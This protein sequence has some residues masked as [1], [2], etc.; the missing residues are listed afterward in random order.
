MTMQAKGIKTITNLAFESTYG[1]QS[2]GTIYRFPF[3]KNAL[4]SKQSL[5]DSNTI[6]GRRDIAAP[7]S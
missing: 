1:V 7:G 3:N 4:T 5:I 2:S 6:T